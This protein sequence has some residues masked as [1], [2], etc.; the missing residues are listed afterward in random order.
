MFHVSWIYEEESAFEIPKKN[1]D[2]STRRGGRA[3]TSSQKQHFL[4]NI[5]D[6]RKQKQNERKR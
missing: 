2:H 3:V 1:Q 6:C 5:F 4:Q